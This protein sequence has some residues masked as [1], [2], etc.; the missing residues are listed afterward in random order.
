MKS[1]RRAA[2]IEHE[3][4]CGTKFTISYQP[5][6]TVDP[7]C[8]ACGRRHQVIRVGSGSQS[9]LEEWPTSTLIRMEDPL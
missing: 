6:A 7:T 1:P 2:V 3:C 4:L 9:R 8:P 5:K